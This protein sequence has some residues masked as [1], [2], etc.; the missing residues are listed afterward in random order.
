MA[1]QNWK[2]SPQSPEP[3][4]TQ[5]VIY[6]HKDAHG[7][8]GVGGGKWGA[9]FWCDPAPVQETL[10]AGHSVYSGFFSKTNIF[11]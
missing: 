9:P 11:D 7:L 8:G 10:R 5:M 4:V 6:P 2:I 3:A 1:Q